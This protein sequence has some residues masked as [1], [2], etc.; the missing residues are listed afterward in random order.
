MGAKSTAKKPVEWAKIFNLK[1]SQVL[2]IN[3]YD[4]EEEKYQVTQTG[5]VGGMQVSIILS[6]DNEKE[7]NKVFRTYTE[8]DAESFYSSVKQ[9]MK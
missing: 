4:T 1:E 7:A 2:V 5:Y 9:L 8:K 3:D 6:Y